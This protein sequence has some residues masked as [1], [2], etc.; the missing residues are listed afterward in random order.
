[1]QICGIDE[2]TALGYG[3]DQISWLNENEK[4]AWEA[5]I[6]RRLLYSTVPSDLSAMINPAPAT[7]LLNQE[8][9]GRAGRFIGHRIV[10]SY[11]RNN[12]EVSLDFLLSPEF[13]M[14][15]QSLAKA[16]YMP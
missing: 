3:Y 11:I 4:Q 10:V 7:T 16:K 9:P 12:P 13:Y 5:L 8:A 15:G 14:S 1:M 6:T 2:K